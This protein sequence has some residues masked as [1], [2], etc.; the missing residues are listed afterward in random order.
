[1]DDEYYD[2]LYEPTDADEIFADASNRLMTALK[3]DVAARI[4]D[5]EMTCK[6]LRAENKE[7]H[8]EIV[9][10][11]LEKAEIA[12]KR[13]ELERM[14]KRMPIS[15]LLG[16]RAVIMYRAD[17]AWEYVPKCDLCDE[18]RGRPYKTPM[19]RDATEHC[20]CARRVMTYTAKEYSMSSMERRG[21]PEV[22]A[23]FKK[24]DD[25]SDSFSTSKI[26]KNENVYNGEDFEDVDKRN[27]FFLDKS[28]C[29]EYCDWLNS[30][31]EE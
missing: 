26:V 13:D 11:N 19:G 18:G 22:Y 9:A 23:W 14:A 25:D 21:D 24:Y 17:S 8:N 7:L 27:T 2:H 5:L 16:Q 6:Q 12:R 30:Q 1:V 28:K 29:Q 15:T 4:A 3:K 31:L 10:A 20:T